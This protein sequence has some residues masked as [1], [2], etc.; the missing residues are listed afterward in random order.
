MAYKHPKEIALAYARDGSNASLFNHASMAHNNHHFFEALVTHP[1]ILYTNRLLIYPS[2][3]CLEPYTKANA[4][5]ACPKRSRLVLLDRILPRYLSR[6][7]RSHVWPRLCMA[8]KAQCGK[9]ACSAQPCHLSYLPRWLPLS[10][11]SLP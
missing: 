2:C 3:L 9:P 11:R 8:C 1:P 4:P 10:R 6:Y 5:T 7:G